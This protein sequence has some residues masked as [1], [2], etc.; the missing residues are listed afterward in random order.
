ME[1]GR[2]GD[3]LRRH[4]PKQARHRQQASTESIASSLTSAGTGNAGA[5]PAAEVSITLSMSSLM[6]VRPCICNADIQVRSTVFGLPV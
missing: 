5:E 1:E 4:A 2:A 3:N 6:I